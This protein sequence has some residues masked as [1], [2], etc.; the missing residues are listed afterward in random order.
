M[1]NRLTECLPP[2]PSAEPLAWMEPCGLFTPQGYEPG[3]DY[4][5]VVWLPDR[6]QP[7][8]LGRAMK[9]LS[10]RNFVAVVPDVDERSGDEP[11]WDAI[12]RVC[13][14]ISIHPRRI[15]LVG[16]GAG[17]SDAFRIACRHPSAFAG[18]VSLGG[19]FP[20]AEGL[21]A[22]LAEVRRLPMLLCCRRTDGPDAARQ[23]DATLRAF[24]AAGAMLSL[25]IYPRSGDLSKAVLGDVNRWLMDDV[26]GTTTPVP[27]AATP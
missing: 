6:S 18:V 1:N 12:D 15:Y 21:F 11:L 25:R 8:D 19:P 24:H 16:Q 27:S 4:P 20:L 3:Y 2:A 13:E 7:F 26:C 10:L 22:R 23:V 5:L 14:R 17:G 9:R